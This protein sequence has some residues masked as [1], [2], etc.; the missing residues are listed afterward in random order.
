MMEEDIVEEEL[1]EEVIDFVEDVAEDQSIPVLA[2]C[3]IHSETNKEDIHKN[4]VSPRDESSLETLL[5]A[6]RIRKCSAVLEIA[7]QTNNN[8]AAFFYHR[9]CRSIFTLKR[10]LDA[11]EPPDIADV[12][13]DSQV[14]PSTS[15]PKRDPSQASIL[16]GNSCILCGKANK[17]K[18]GASHT[19]EPLRQ[20]LESRAEER[21]RQYAQQTADTRLLGLV[22]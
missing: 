17:Y 11:I 1:F 7:R 14:L 8:P 15:R 9:S 3:L 12:E 6:A 2:K 19:R 10:Y 16:L 21:I 4:L 13:D 20:C 18:K 22:D 5:E